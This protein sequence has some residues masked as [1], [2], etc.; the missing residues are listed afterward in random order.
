MSYRILTID[1]GSTGTGGIR[2]VEYEEGIYLGY[3]YYETFW[4][5]IAQGNTSLTEGKDPSEY[6]AIADAWHDFNVVYPFGF[7]LSYTDFALSL[8]HI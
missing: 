4:H 2:G 5:E 6:Q 3:K 8:I 7:G 1:P